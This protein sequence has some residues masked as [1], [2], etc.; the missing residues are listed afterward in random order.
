[1]IRKKN[2]KPIGMEY[3]AV[4]KSQ[5]KSL[6]MWFNRLIMS[7]GLIDLLMLASGQGA[8]LS[9]YLGEHTPVILVAVGFIGAWLRKRTTGAVK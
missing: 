4:V 3:T 8:I 2:K 7:A 9:K 6:S 5:W 1:M